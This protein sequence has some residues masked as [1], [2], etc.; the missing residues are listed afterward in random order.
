MKWFESRSHA[1]LCKVM[2]AAEIPLQ[3]ILAVSMLL[4]VG[5]TVIDTLAHYQEP[6]WVLL[7]GGVCILMAFLCLVLLVSFHF[8][9]RLWGKSIDDEA[10]RKLRNHPLRRNILAEW[11]IPD[12][13]RK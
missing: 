6:L 11:N 13:E 1:N 12:D 10:R 2:V 8:Y 3:C 5:A 9:I 7:A 4:V